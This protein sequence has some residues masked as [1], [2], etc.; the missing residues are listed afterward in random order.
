RHVRASHVERVCRRAVAHA[1]DGGD[2][3]APA[4]PVAMLQAHEIAVRPV[5]VQRDEGHF[6]V[7]H[8]HGI[9]LQASPSAV[10]LRR[11]WPLLPAGGL[12]S[13]SGASSALKRSYKRCRYA[14]SAANNPSITPV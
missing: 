14:R 9:G 13:A 7:E 3:G 2:L 5:E 12:F 10:I 6:L 11:A 1:V 8:L 4:T